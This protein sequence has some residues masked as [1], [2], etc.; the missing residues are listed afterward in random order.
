MIRTAATG[1]YTAKI[2]AATAV[3]RR[4]RIPVIFPKFIR[5]LI[6]QGFTLREG[7]AFSEVRDQLT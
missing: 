1:S 7:P 3:E 2:K 5:N 4:A 6:G